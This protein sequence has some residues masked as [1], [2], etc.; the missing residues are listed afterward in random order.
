MN[1][2]WIWVIRYVVVIALALVLGAVLGEM[3]LF[4][5]TKLGKTGLNAAHFAQFLGYG[6]ALLVFWLFARR[7]AGELDGRDP[8]WNPVKSI[9]LPLATLIV[10]ACMQAVLLLVLGPLMSKAWHQ[11]YNWVFIAAI[12]A[13]AAWLV[14]A[15]L[16]GSASLSGIFGASGRIA[17][18]QEKAGHRA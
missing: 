2:R 17:R 6:G 8:R 10:V 4:K 18:R 9:A 7:A 1:E 5:T 14:A 16:T 13:S 11:A 15:L 3:A 12:M